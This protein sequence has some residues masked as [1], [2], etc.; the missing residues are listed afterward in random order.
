MSNVKTL[1]YKYQVIDKR[2]HFVFTYTDSYTEA[3]RII[4]DFNNQRLSLRQPVREFDI[5]KRRVI[6]L[7]YVE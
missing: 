2:T 7:C 5:V 6:G 4:N 3:E 1:G